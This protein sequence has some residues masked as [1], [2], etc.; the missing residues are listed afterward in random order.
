MNLDL[1]EDLGADCHCCILILGGVN[2]KSN[3]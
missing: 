3:R 1:F 2:A